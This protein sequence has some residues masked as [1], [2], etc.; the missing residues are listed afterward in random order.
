M[1]EFAPEGH[2]PVRRPEQRR[3]R[4][5]RRARPTPCGRTACRCSASATACRRWRRSWAARSRPGTVREF[6]YA[7]VRARGH[8][9]LLRDIEDRAQRRRARA[10]RRLDEPR[11]QG[12]RAAA[13]LHADR[14]SVDA[15]AIAAMAD[16]SRGF[17][18][19]AVPSRGHAHEAGRGDPRALRARHLRLR[20]G[21]EHARL[22]RRGGG[23]DPRAGR[24]R[25]RAC[26]ACPAAST[27]RSPRRSSI[28]RD[29]RPAHL[30][31]RRPRPAAAGRGRRR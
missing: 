4:A 14:Q 1:R 7:E 2:H 22:R 21:L 19:R 5:T 3:P 24:R 20:R 29:R 8:S 11:R 31:V 12:H 9:T 25:R 30:R 16:E 10:A 13:G 23:G 26:S 17:Y 28:K 18:A 6:G 15:C 27:R